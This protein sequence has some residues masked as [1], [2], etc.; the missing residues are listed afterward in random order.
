MITI[1]TDKAIAMG[2]H[3]DFVEFELANDG[4]TL[5]ATDIE[6]QSGFLEYLPEGPWK[7]L[8]L[9]KDLTEEQWREV[10]E[11]VS[12]WSKVIYYNYSASGRDYR[13]TVEAAFDNTTE[14]GLS[15]LRSKGLQG[16]NTLILIKQ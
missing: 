1:L 11:T 3:E 6:G 7:I 16:D 15:L 2:V 12:G 8:G 13:D 9:G 10:V 4:R 14:S 5:V